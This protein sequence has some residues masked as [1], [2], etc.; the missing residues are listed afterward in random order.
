MFAVDGKGLTDSSL[1]IYM[2]SVCWTYHTFYN[3][4]GM[5]HTF[6]KYLK[7]CCR[8]SSDEKFSFKYLIERYHQNCQSILAAVS[9]NELSC[10]VT[11]VLIEPHMMYFAKMPSLNHFWQYL[12]LVTIVSVK[13]YINVRAV[14]L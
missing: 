12:S 1:E 7:G 5:K 6:A 14:A 3:N 11:I 2:T 8:M 10:P 13:T 9:M 4:F